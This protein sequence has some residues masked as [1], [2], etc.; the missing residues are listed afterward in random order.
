MLRKIDHI[1]MAVHSID[2]A[3][4]FYEQV[5]G[6]VCERIEEL[7]DHGVRTAFFALG[8]VHLEL[9]EP[10]GEDSPIARFLAQRGE[11]MHHIS[12]AS[13]D[14][15]K[16]LERAR[17]G[18]SRLLHERPVAGAGGKLI[19]F[20]HPRSSHGVLTELCGKAVESL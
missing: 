1:G 16:D 18:G 14:L 13:D 9:L 17:A 2:Q 19:A 10:L 11:G 15:T 20:L 4:I 8:G 3:R 7:P 5:L 6:L 12:Y